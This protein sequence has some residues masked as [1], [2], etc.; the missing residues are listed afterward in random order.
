[1][2]N[3][4][5]AIPSYEREKTLYNKSL[6]LLNYYNIPKKN[7][8]IF[9]ANET[10]KNNYNKLLLNQ[11]KIIIGKKGI[12]NI[13]N[14][15]AKY[16]K[17]NEKIF[18]LDD[19]ISYIYEVYNKIDKNNRKYNK[20]K[21]LK[22]LDEFIKNSFKISE[23]NNITNWGIY[24]VENPYFMKLKSKNLNNYISLDLKYIMGGF[25]GVINN[26][27]CEIRTVND[28]ED[29]ERSIKYYLKDNGIMRFNNICVRTNCYTEKGGMQIDRTKEKIHNSAIK[30]LNKYPKLCKLN[31]TKKSDYTELRLKDNR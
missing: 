10:E 19:D 20:L 30:L 8:Y 28:K 3:Y 13:R 2:S 27:K 24:P 7:I 23:I 15:M 12:K 29:Y 31:M 22:N 11:Y 17:E 4:K 6:K 5:I 25:T 26:H 14:F 21:L 16:F 9:V 18:Y 1:M